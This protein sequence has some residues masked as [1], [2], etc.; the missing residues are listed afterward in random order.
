MASSI[1]AARTWLVNAL[2]AAQASSLSGVL[3]VRTGT[4]DETPDL[5]RV[6]VRNA[7]NIAREWAQLGGRRLTEEYEIPVY[8]ETVTQSAQSDTSNVE[9]RLWQL[10]TAVEQIIVQNPTMSGLLRFA[11]P[12]G[13]DQ[14]ES[15]SMSEANYGARITLTIACTAVV[16]L[17]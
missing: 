2:T 4:W 5:E 1:P 12:A 10:V 15:G 8:V 11:R 6:E 17:S 16:D 9:A 13:A 7:R 3:I 14:E